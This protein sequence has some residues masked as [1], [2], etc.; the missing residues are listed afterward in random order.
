MIKDV[1]KKT[2]KEANMTLRAFAKVLNVA[3]TTVSAWE[4]GV[5]TPRMNKI[6]EMSEK[7]NV[8]IQD[9]FAGMADPDLVHREGFDPL[10][11]KHP[12]FIAEH[13]ASYSY[14]QLPYFRNLAAAALS[15]MTGIVEQDLEFVTLPKQMIGNHVASDELFALHIQSES[16]N[17][18]IPYGSFIICIKTEDQHVDDGD[19][20]IMNNEK[21]MKLMRYRLVNEQI[22]FEPETNDPK[23]KEVRKQDSSEARIIGKVVSYSVTLT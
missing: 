18:L 3:P 19:I 1:V 15:V 16:M 11:T 21:Q 2:R 12:H 5:N 10:H 9:F 7:F 13:E 23:Y 22:V 17:Q 6:S 20:V 8:N 4:R 14:V